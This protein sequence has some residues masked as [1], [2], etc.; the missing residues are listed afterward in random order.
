M[1]KSILYPNNLYKV[2]LL[3]ALLI[4]NSCKENL[5]LEKEIDEIQFEV[6]VE[7]FDKL[8]MNSNKEKFL[9]HKSDFPFLFPKHIPD[10]VLFKRTKDPVQKLIKKSVDSVFFDFNSIEDNLVS[11]FKHIKYYNPSLRKPRLI[12]VFSDVDY[13]NKVIVTDTIVLIGIDNYLGSEHPFYQGFF[14]YIRKNLKK[15]QIVVDLA[16]AYAARMIN[17]TV[18]N[19][20]L[21]ELI[22]QGKKMYLKDLWLPKCQDHIKIGYT[23]DELN[24]ANDNEFYIWEY[25]I[26]NKLLYDTN[27]KLYERFIAKAP[28]SRFN[29]ELDNESPPSLGIY[30]GWKII[31]SYLDNNNIS[32]INMLQADSQSIFK[33]AKFKPRK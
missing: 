25:F 15:D 26:E 18:R 9:K 28:F 20:F 17:Q 24:W 13:R 19:T 3:F 1:I 4:I 21:D 7:R 6:K 16:D 27:P 31:R 10:S 2:I 23:V 33:N 14:K 12:T 29:L 11:L 32:L 22:Y 30:I 5:T 8:F